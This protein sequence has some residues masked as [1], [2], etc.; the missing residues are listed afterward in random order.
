MQ[1]RCVIVVVWVTA[2]GLAACGGQA[3]DVDEVTTTVATTESTEASGAATTV[4]STSVTTLAPTTTT[5]TPDVEP[6]WVWAWL[7]DPAQIVAI[8]TD[9]QTNPLLDTPDPR[10]LNSVMLWQVAPDK[11]LT[12]YVEGGEVTAH[13]LTTTDAIEVAFPSVQMAAPG[14]TWTLLALS[15]PHVVIR[16]PYGVSEA[17]VL[18]NTDTSEATLLAP[19]VAGMSRAA[20]FSAD[21]RYLRFVTTGGSGYPSQVVE[22]DL[23]SGENRT[24]YSYSNFDHVFADATGD[25]W[26][27]FRT[28]D[29]IAADGRAT[30]GS[31]SASATTGRWLAGEWFMT[32]TYGCG[33]DCTLTLVPVSGSAPALTY[34]IPEK[35]ANRGMASWLL[36]DHSLL[37]LDFASSSFWRLTEDGEAQLVGHGDPYQNFTALPNA[38]YAVISTEDGEP[39]TYSALLEVRTGAII[40]LPTVAENPGELYLDLQRNGL[41]VTRYE[42]P[43]GQSVWVMPYDTKVFTALPADADTYCYVLLEDGSAI[44]TSDASSEDGGVQRYEPTSG[45]LTR[46]FDE[47]VYLLAVQP[48]AS[49]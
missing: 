23:T 35:S 6:Q 1:N 11:A 2:F 38:P 22:R 45:T 3:A 40:P 20:M 32:Y 36:D 39:V 15:G 26:L 34:V 25:V 28:G 31:H 17:A 30:N 5:S 24:L 18:I 47:T 7:S 10:T 12:M 41:L 14:N 9:G 29:V 44:C 13:L 43:D 19:N 27:D 8:S 49:S 16:Y 37:V 33:N 46:I 42:P 48:P 21:G 4:T